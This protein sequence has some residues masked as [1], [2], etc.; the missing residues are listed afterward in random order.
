MPTPGPLWICSNLQRLLG[1]ALGLRCDGTGACACTVVVIVGGLV[2]DAVLVC[3]GRD[4]CRTAGCCVVRVGV[5]GACC[6]PFNVQ[7]DGELLCEPYNRS[8]GKL[9]QNDH[10]GGQG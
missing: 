9:L 10:H 8:I 4:G 5:R 3:L 7:L 6:A 2:A 1:A